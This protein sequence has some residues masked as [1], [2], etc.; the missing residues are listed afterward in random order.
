MDSGGLEPGLEMREELAVG[1]EKKEKE[2]E[3]GGR[4]GGME[5]TVG[6]G[7]CGT[8][9]SDFGRRSEARWSEGRPWRTG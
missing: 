2:R 8:V 6:I 5:C 3:E 4:L 7:Q 1:K 9:E